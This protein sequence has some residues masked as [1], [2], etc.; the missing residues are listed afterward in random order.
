MDVSQVA[1]TSVPAERER[2]NA[3]QETVLR[4]CVCGDTLA[5]ELSVEADDS[6]Y[7]SRLGVWFSDRGRLKV[8]IPISS[9]S[10]VRSQLGRC[11]RG[12]T[13]GAATSAIGLSTGT[14]G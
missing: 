9:D 8:R 2:P 10:R 14:N 3:V 4:C 11:S 12:V 5:N 7:D 6:S 1:I 13:P